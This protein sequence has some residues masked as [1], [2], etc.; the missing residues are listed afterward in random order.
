MIYVW[1]K[2]GSVEF[3][4]TP[5]S[6]AS[7]ISGWGYILWCRR[8]KQRPVRSCGIWYWS[9][10]VGECGGW[11]VQLLATEAGPG[12]DPGTAAGVGLVSMRSSTD[13]DD[14]SW[15]L[16]CD[17]WWDDNAARI[18][19]TCLGYTRSPALSLYLCLC[20]CLFL[21]LSICLLHSCNTLKR[22]VIQTC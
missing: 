7:Q 6:S 15:G 17:D 4:L 10:C 22:L 19:C 12:Q 21:C 1:G 14:G 3:S 2:L 13:A 20:L 11:R 9:V 5:L 8:P 16:V 18:I